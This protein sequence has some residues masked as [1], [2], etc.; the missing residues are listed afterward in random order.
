MI[1]AE[2]Y[3]LGMR[4]LAAGVSIITSRDEGR[5]HGFAATS[6]SSVAAEPEPT[7]LVCVNRSASSHDVIARSGI[8]CVNLLRDDD[9]ETAQRFS[10]PHLRHARFEGREWMP[11]TTGAP[12]LS[13]ALVSF[14]CRV[15][16]TM[17]VHSHTIF[18][19]EVVDIHISGEPATPLLYFDGR[20]EML[21]AVG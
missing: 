21:G 2:K 9:A 3:R 1:A 4:R 5:L 6:V 14:D 17:Q 8:F 15:A 18:L 13:C 12:A 19:G 20:Y 16:G 11:L 7:L 10:A